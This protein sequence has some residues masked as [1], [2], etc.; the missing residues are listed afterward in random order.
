M[1]FITT[2]VI[3]KIKINH[4]AFE[5]FHYESISLKLILK[6]NECSMIYIYDYIVLERS[7]GSKK[8]YNIVL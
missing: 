1:K 2:C 6:I 8:L 7:C 3:R 4:T 5:G